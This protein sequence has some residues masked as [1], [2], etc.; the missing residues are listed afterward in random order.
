VEVIMIVTSSESKGELAKALARAQGQI[1]AALKTS[2]NPHFKSK[3]ADLAEVWSVVRG[4]LSEAQIAVIQSPDCE[5]E[6]MYLETMLAHASGEWIKGRFLLKPTKPDMQ[7]LG[8]AITY[9][10]RYSLA[11]MVG[12]IQE[13]DDGNE[14]STPARQTVGGYN[15]NNP[16]HVKALKASLAA[17]NIRGVHFTNVLSAMVGRPMTDLEAIIKAA[18]PNTPDGE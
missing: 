15:P 3:F 17:K 11:A 7:G 13:D 8:S 6:T 18:N 5:G 16:D 2:T 14:A 9:A 4:P 1:G 12:V 10:R